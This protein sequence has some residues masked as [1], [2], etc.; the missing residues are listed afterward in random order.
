MQDGRVQVKQDGQVHHF[1]GVEQLVF[2]AEALNLVK[3]KCHFFGENLI[4]GDSCD[5][6]GGAIMNLVESKRCLTRVDLNLS[7]L[8]LKLPGNFIL[9]MSHEANEELTENVDFLLLLPVVFMALFHCKPECLTHNVVEWDGE[10]VATKGKQ[11]HAVNA[12]ELAPLSLLV[13]CVINPDCLPPLLDAQWQRF[14][15][16][17]SFEFLV[18]VFNWLQ[19]N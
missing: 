14:L 3:V 6:L 13:K 15:K 1:T 7:F 5:R 18:D 16:P 11:D 9:G 17:L 2:E 10:E 8:W 12:I 19:L 4:Y